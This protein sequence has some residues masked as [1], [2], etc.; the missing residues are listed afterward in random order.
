MEI[1]REFI[2]GWFAGKS[3]FSIRSSILIIFQTRMTAGG[4]YYTTGKKNNG[5]PFLDILG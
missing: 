3:S 4:D 2:A 1:A 5:F